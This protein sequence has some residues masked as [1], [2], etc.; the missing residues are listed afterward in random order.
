[1][2]LLRY[3]EVEFKT[4]L[5]KQA[6]RTRVSAGTFPKPV[7]LGIRSDGRATLDAFVET[8]IDAWIELTIAE[9]RNRARA[10]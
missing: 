5:K 1:M 9:G 7:P 10:T 4:G 3:S 8:E 2:R 6:I